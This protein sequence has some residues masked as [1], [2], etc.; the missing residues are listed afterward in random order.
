MVIEVTSTTDAAVQAETPAV[1]VEGAPSVLEGEK[2]AEQTAAKSDTAEPEA[3]EAKEDEDESEAEGDE[4]EAEGAEQ[5]GKPRK[6][7]GSQRRKERAERAEAEVERLRKVVEDMALKGAGAP[8]D[9]PK[10]EPAKAV[11]G[12]PDP[13]DF[14]THAAYVKAVVKWDR[15]QSDKAKDAEA[16]KAKLAEAQQTAVKTYAEREK[17]FSAEV[18]DFKEAVAEIDDIV[19]P[20]AVLDAVTSSELGP[21]ITYELAKNREEAERIAK[22]PPGAAYM[23]IG[24]L[25][26]TI[27]ARASAPKPEPKKLTK[28]PQPITPVGAKG[29]TVEKSLHEVAATGSQSEYEAMRRKQRDAKAG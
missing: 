12:E 24:E 19:F 25:V 29:G 8:K 23:A 13:D 27:K 2:P 11:D 6:K 22:L 5:D 28:A 21:Q 10:A 26:A 14:D 17:A 15:E 1:Q 7:S 18:K 20:G 3:K 4:P 16:Q 9:E